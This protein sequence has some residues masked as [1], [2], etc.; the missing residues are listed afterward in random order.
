MSFCDTKLY[1]KGGL[2]Y[3]RMNQKTRIYMPI[4]K[5]LQLTTAF[6]FSFPQSFEDDLRELR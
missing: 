1:Y 5:Y 4:I 6:H 3:I 2:T